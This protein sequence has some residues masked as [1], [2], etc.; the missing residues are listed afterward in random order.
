MTVISV[1]QLSKSY[2]LGSIGG[3]TL[4]ADVSRWL[5]RLRGKEDPNS[6]IG[7]GR[8]K[9]ADRGGKTADRRSKMADGTPTPISQ[10]PS[11]DRDLFWALRDVSFEVQQGEILGIIG[12]PREIGIHPPTQWIGKCTRYVCLASHAELPFHRG[13][14]GAGK[15]TLLKIL[16][17]ITEPTTGCVQFQRF[18]F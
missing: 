13:T 7:D 11:P 16:S 6:K 12:L 18:S 1:E 3:G 17:R 2:R 8:L 4:R 5:A 10:L 15:S 9:M 14:N